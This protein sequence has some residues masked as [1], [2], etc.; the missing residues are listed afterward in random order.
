MRGGTR[1]PGTTDL[2]REND[3]PWRI[4][5]QKGPSAKGNAIRAFPEAR[6]ELVDETVEKC[7]WRNGVLYLV[8]T[9]DETVR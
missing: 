4:C 8:K 1:H 5:Q 6:N 9:G 2:Q 7:K 3:T